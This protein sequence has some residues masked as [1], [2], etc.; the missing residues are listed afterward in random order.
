MKSLFITGT[1]TGVGKTV[2]AAALTYMARTTGVDAVLMKPI[3]TGCTRA[4]PELIAPDLDFCLTLCGLKPSQDERE[5]MSPIR[6]EPAC[7]PHLAAALAGESIDLDR[8]RTAYSALHGKHEVVVVEGAGGLLVPIN[9]EQTIAD[10]IALL[11]LPVLVVARPGL[12]T[13]NHSFLTLTELRR[14]KAKVLGVVAV[15]TQPAPDGIIEEDNAR[16]IQRMGNVPFFGSV[17]YLEELTQG[18][19]AVEELISAFRPVYERIVQA[20]LDVS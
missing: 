20:L 7:S 16:T 9:A 8:I 13:L 6:F 19:V 3:Q 1:D 11:Q 18:Q 2:V 4:G 10:L 12:G 14:R 15:H 17:G 5:L